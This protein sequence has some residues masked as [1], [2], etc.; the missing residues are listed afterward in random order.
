MEHIDITIAFEGEQ[1]LP[2]PHPWF[3]HFYVCISWVMF[4]LTSP[5]LLE[6]GEQDLPTPFTFGFF[7]GIFNH[8]PL[9]WFYSY[10]L[11]YASYNKTRKNTSTIAI[12]SRGEQDLPTPLLVLFFTCLC[13]C[14]VL[15]IVVVIVLLQFC[16]HCCL[17]CACCRSVKRNTST[18][19][20]SF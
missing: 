5:S 7:V 20:F 11:S 2:P 3:F 12:T 14:I 9:V 8:L 15:T 19:T 6:G 18:I 10:V 16:S 4:V 17:F 13:C 1:D